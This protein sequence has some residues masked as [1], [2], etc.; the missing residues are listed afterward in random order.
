[1]SASCVTRLVSGAL[2]FKHG[3]GR[4]LPCR[5]FHTCLLCVSCSW[6]FPVLFFA[7]FVNPWRVIFLLSLLFAC[8]PTAQT[9]PAQNIASLLSV[10]RA[11]RGMRVGRP[12]PFNG[13]REGCACL[14]A[15]LAEFG[16]RLWQAWAGI[17]DQGTNHKES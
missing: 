2:K 6:V 14:L 10:L 1:M 7:L 11:R 12:N 8:C 17:L 4:F 16:G 5:C 13:D 15:C 9:L 3:R